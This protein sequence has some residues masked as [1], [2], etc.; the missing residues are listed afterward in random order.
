MTLETEVIIF[1]SK[2]RIKFFRII[3]LQ[4]RLVI[5][6]VWSM[7][8]PADTVGNRLMLRNRI[9]HKVLDS[10]VT[11]EAITIAGLTQHG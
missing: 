2:G 11:A 8:L 3:S 9:I 1:F 5:R 4:K 10:R 6:R 7:A